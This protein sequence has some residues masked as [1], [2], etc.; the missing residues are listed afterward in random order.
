MA[1]L[2]A[3]RAPSR[4]ARPL[5]VLALSCA[6]ARS[7][8][9]AR[10]PPPTAVSPR[11]SCVVAF[12]IESTAPDEAT[13]I[14]TVTAENMTDAAVDFDLPDRCPHS[15]LALDGL[16]DDFDAR[17]TCNAGACPGPRPPV[18]IH[19]APRERRA[20]ST[21]ELPLDGTS[22]VPPLPRD[23]VLIG[24]VIP[25]LPLPACGGSA[26]VDLR[27]SPSRKRPPPPLVTPAAP[28]T[29]TAD[30]Y[31]CTSPADCVLSCPEAPGCC[32]WPCGC[33]HAIRRDHAAEFEA[34]YAKTCSPRVPH[35]PDVAC[36][37]QQALFATCRAGRCVGVTNPSGR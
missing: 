27:G 8:D 28:P 12:G 3:P 14:V 29:D 15:L 17:L 16:P 22:C 9:V 6:P 23:I 36:L 32:G 10:P 30:P 1:A 5:V 18:H 4:A 13:R 2:R 31:A 34:N 35:C 19:L 7:S 11:Q 25:P 20:V 21:T 26:P 37:R 24:P 33:Q